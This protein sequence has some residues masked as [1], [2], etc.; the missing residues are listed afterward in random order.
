MK[1]IIIL[2]VIIMTLINRISSLELPQYKD[3]E[4]KPQRPNTYTL[5]N[6]I[7]VYLEE[8]KTL[9]II[10][11]SILMRGG[12]VID[13]VN[14]VGLG[15]LFYTVW[16]E[17]G[18]KKYSPQDID[19]TLEYYA[20]DIST[21]INMEDAYLNMISHKN[22]FDK[23][24]DIF[25]DLIKNPEFD[26]KKFEL[27]KLEAIEMIK[28]RNDKADQQAV[29][30][31]MR[32][33]F[34][35][36]H[37]YGRRAEIE[38]INNITRDDLFNYHA[39]N[40]VSSNMIIVAAG[41]FNKEEFFEKLK[42]SFSDIIQ[43]EFSPTTIQQPQIP[44]SRK[45]YV[46]DKPLRQSSIVML[47][48]GPKRHDNSEFPLAV[49]SEYMGGGIQSVLGNEIRS[50]RGL[51]YS[52]YSYFGKRDVSGFVLTYVGTKPETVSDA[53][54]QIIYEMEKAKND[55]DD[56]GFK[57][58]KSQL[59]NSFVFRF[60]TVFDLLEEFAGYDQ[61]GYEKD[62]LEKYT[63]RI[64]SVSKADI[65]DAA[66]RFYKTNKALIFIVG[67]A[68]KFTDSLKELGEIE[69]IKED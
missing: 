56:A 63:S 64:N 11:I 22:S 38:T 46:I 18:S 31:A 32:M 54:K 29:R 53:L 49:L 44:Q 13:P 41:D 15:E 25:V 20:A 27:K 50:K 1:K 17:G 62:Y 24:F 36:D 58:A 42:I 59:V 48:E 65:F 21:K 7:K 69:F 37:P 8:D 68:K 60:P 35:K 10:K 39:S 34:G 23:I 40:F 47:M 67:D 45:I 28:R 66:K 5:P 12:K 33:F 14:K 51:A 6:G 43:K 4:F 30:E 3:I 16:R 55:I 52:V 57:N 2:G 9:P 61:Y 26:N 19:K